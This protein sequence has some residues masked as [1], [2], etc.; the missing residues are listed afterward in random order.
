[1]TCIETDNLT[2]TFDSRPL[3][4]GLSLRVERGRRVRIA[5]PSGCGKSTLLKCLMGFVP[6]FSGTI[7]IERQE[8]DAESVWTLRRKLAYLAQ[9]P[10]LGTGTVL[11]RLREPFGYRHNAGMRFDREKLDQWL[12]YYHLPRGI[13]AHDLATLSGGEKQRLA[14]ISMIML[15]RTIFLL[16]EPVSALD[17]RSRRQFVRMF[18]EH[19]DWTA[20]FVSHDESLA[21][22]A[23]ETV[24]LAAVQNGGLR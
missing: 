7:R 5:G 16:D 17:A 24:D 22:L 6:G 8:L 15:E 3:W 4:Q 21:E 20:V 12:D 10:Q 9:E 18:Q 14:V 1:M 23:D 13:V 19:P 2:V 11:S